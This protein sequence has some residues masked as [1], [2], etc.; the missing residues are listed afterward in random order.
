MKKLILTLTLICSSVFAL[1]HSKLEFKLEDML[2][3]ESVV[4]VLSVET[5]ENENYNVDLA[6]DAGHA[7]RMIT[8]EIKWDGDQKV[9]I[10]KCDKG[11]EWFKTLKSN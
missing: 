2:R 10:K 4:A 3:F 1:D 7:S 9:E 11:L 6:I 5:L 8:C